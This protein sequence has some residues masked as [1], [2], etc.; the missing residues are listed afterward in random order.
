MYCPAGSAPWPAA[1]SA[2]ASWPAAVSAAY[3]ATLSCLAVAAAVGRA[4]GSLASSWPISGVSGPACSGAGGSP[5]RMAATTAVSVGPANGGLPSVIA[6]KVAAER[7]QVGRRAD[8]MALKLL[9]RHV[10]GGPED[11]PGAGQLAG[12]VV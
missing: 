2:A 10:V 9:R 4:P 11:R 7:P 5:A 12:R 6:Y 1:F 8:R 3:R